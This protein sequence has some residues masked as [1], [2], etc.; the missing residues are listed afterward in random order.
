MSNTKSTTEKKLPPNETR[1]NDLIG[2]VSV[3]LNNHE[4]FNDFASELAHYNPK[5]FKAVA[6]KFFIEKNAIITL[7]AVDVERKSRNTENQKLP[8]HKFKFEMSLENFFSK[9]KRFNFTLT[10]GN[11]DIETMEVVN[12]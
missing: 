4:D 10:A 1:Y 2:V 11:Y 12:K 6:L 9:V 7:Y 5:R 3:N 8:V